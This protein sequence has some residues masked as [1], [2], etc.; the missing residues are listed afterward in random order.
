MKISGFFYINTTSSILS[1]KEVNSRLAK[2]EKP[3]FTNRK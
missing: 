2:S 1:F 3:E